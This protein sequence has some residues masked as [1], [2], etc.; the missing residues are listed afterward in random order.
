VRVFLSEVLRGEDVAFEEIDQDCWNILYYTTLLAR[1][2]GSR[3][4][5]LSARSATPV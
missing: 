2:D 1:W 3:K 4:Q 5:L